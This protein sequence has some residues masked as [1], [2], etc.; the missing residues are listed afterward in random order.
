VESSTT[1][2]LGAEI[3]N[4][5]LTGNA[6]ID[7]TGNDAANVIEGNAGNNVLDGGAGYDTLVGGAG[8]DTYY[9]EAV[10]SGDVIVELANE[11]IDTVY[12]SVG[13]MLGADVEN[14][15][16]LGATAYEAVGNDLANVLVGNT[17]DN[18]WKASEAPTPCAAVPATTPTTSITPGMLS[19]RTRTK[20]SDT[21]QSTVFLCA[22]K[23]RRKPVSV[24]RV[25]SV[26][27]GQLSGEQHLRRHGQ[28]HARRQRRR[29]H[30][31]R[32]LGRRHLLRRQQCRR[33][34]R[35]SWRGHR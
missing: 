7:G 4:L 23:Q 33:H 34:R 26:R 32:W 22:R 8:N 25:R 10:N 2:A 19:S 5:V 13:Y 17:A 1:Y 31:G 11:G 24:R 12:S 6:G 30:A 29:R 18:C 35:V 14:L 3:E 27:Y 9:V 28:R 21:V 20:V 16:L 15:T